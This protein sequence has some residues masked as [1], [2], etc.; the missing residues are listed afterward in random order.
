MSKRPKQTCSDAWNHAPL[1][2]PTDQLWNHML[3]VGL[4][5]D[6]RYLLHLPTLARPSNRLGMIQLQ[7]MGPVQRYSGKNAHIWH[8]FDLK[9]DE[10]CACL[11]LFGQFKPLQTCSVWMDFAIQNSMILSC[12]SSNFAS[13]NFRAPPLSKAKDAFA[14]SSGTLQ[15]PAQPRSP[16]HPFSLMI[17]PLEMVMFHCK[18]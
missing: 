7:E 4:D 15:Q 9:L 6:H 1:D 8:M 10:I 12:L 14:A 5:L 16:G 2:H 13:Q 3:Y 11:I 18:L 17:Y